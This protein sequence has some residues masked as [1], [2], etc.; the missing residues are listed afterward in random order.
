MTIPNQAQVQQIFSDASNWL[1]PQIRKAPHNQ[2]I[3]DLNKRAMSMYHGWPLTAKVPEGYSIPSAVDGCDY[4]R[5][6]G[7]EVHWSVGSPP[8][9]YVFPQMDWTNVFTRSDTT[10][11]ARIKI[12]PWI[13]GQPDIFVQV[14]RHNHA[15]GWVTVGV[16]YEGKPAN[17][18]RYYPIQLYF[19]DSRI[20]ADH[21]TQAAGWVL[22]INRW[23]EQEMR[24]NKY[25]IRTEDMPTAKLVYNIPDCARMYNF[26]DGTGW[27]DNRAD[28]HG[29]LFNSGF[30]SQPDDFM[31]L[32]PPAP[33]YWD[34]SVAHSGCPQG[35]PSDMHRGHSAGGWGMS[36]RSKV[37]VWPQAYTTVLRQDPLGLLSQA[38]FIMLKYNNPYHHYANP[39]PSWAPG[40]PPGSTIRPIDMVQ[41]VGD[42]F[43]EPGVGMTMFNVPIVGVDRRGSSLRTNQHLVACTLLGYHFQASNPPRADAALWRVRADSVADILG[44]TQVGGV[45][46]AQPPNGVW[47][48]NGG[49]I[50]RNGYFG[51]Q[52]FVWDKVGNPTV[53]LV[54]FGWLRTTINELFNLPSDDEDY[55]LSTAETTATYAQAMRVWAYHKYGMVL[56]WDTAT[57]PGYP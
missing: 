51:S 10:F 9:H 13:D 1:L 39:W 22:W 32:N 24:G 45:M 48:V 18:T 37:C 44:K 53:G 7:S 25:F 26:I 27:P 19:E 8:Y 29:P 40:G 41:W 56:G 16:Y 46:G 4:V 38:I 42:N 54:N 35:W 55:T 30:P 17:D 12:G 50:R 3:Y 47:T 28:I 33:A 31:F 21:R 43:W 11:Q 2:G 23:R 5:H 6:M 14:Y 52:L 34:C 15:S 57:L 49:T 20:I 36:H